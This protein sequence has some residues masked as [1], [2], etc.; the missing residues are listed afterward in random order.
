MV[1]SRSK[2]DRNAEHAGMSQHVNCAVIG[3]GIMGA[4][5]AYALSSRSARVTLFEQFPLFHNNGSSHGTTRLFREAYFEHPDYVPLARRAR[6]QWIKLEKLSGKH[7]FHPTSILMAGAEDGPT[8]SGVLRAARQ[9]NIELINLNERDRIKNFPWL[10]L[11]QQATTLIETGA[12]VLSAQTAHQALL[13]CTQA[14]GAIIAEK[15]PV[16]AIEP[17]LSQLTVVTDQSRLL[18]DRVIVTPGAYAPKLLP[19][20]GTMVQPVRKTLFWADTEDPTHTIQS[21]FLP[22][23]IE[24]EDQQFFYSIPSVDKDGLKYG[25]HHDGAVVDDPLDSPEEA[26]TTDREEIENFLKTY[27][28][29]LPQAVTKTQSCLYEMSPDGHFIIDHHPKDD[30]ITF[31][32]GGSGHGFK[33]APVIGDALADLTLKGETLREFDFLKANRFR[34]T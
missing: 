31:A 20:I 6:Q 4:A 13:S 18:F 15:T 7:I 24:T 5:A 1:G 16:L 34:S 11:P 8:L 17:S 25:Q 26:I 33:F 19:D 27:T 3:A 28:P 9:H 12:G 32:L 21:G 22:F 29:G 23:C 30:R 14:N 10:T 2:A